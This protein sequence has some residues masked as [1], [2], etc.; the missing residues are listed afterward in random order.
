[1]E[2]ELRGARLKP[3][4]RVCSSMD[5]L[6]SVQSAEANT[7]FYQSTKERNPLWF[8]GGRTGFRRSESL[9]QP[10]QPMI[11]VKLTSV[12]KKP[13]RFLVRNLTSFYT[14]S[15]SIFLFFQLAIKTWKTSFTSLTFTV[16]QK[17]TWKYHWI[18]RHIGP[19]EQPRKSVVQIGHIK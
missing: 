9:Q 13:N 5:S 2:A 8:Q 10:F 16:E 12:P 15:N 4:I 19:E 18:Y 7:Y 3:A 6:F 11:H 17:R 1:M 14:L